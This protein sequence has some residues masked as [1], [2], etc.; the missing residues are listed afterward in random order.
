MA[1]RPRLAGRRGRRAAGRRRR[2]EPPVAGAGGGVGH[3]AGG[4]GAGRPEPRRG[5]PRRRHG[6]ADRQVPGALGAGRPR[7]RP[8]EECV[9]DARRRLGAG[10]GRAA[11]PDVPRLLGAAADAVCR[12][13]AA[14]L[15][16]PAT[17]P[18]ARS[19]SEVSE[20]VLAG[21]AGEPFPAAAR[22]PSEMA[23]DMTRW[24]TPVTS[25]RAARLTVRLGSPEDDGGWLLTV[26]AQGEPGPDGATAVPQPVEEVLHSG[27]PARAAAVETEL[28]RLERLLPA[29]RRPGRRRGQ[30]V[31]DGTEAWELMTTGGAVLEAAGFTVRVPAAGQEAVDAPPPAPRRGLRRRRRSSAPSSCRG[32]SGRWR[33]TTSRSTPPPSASWPCRPVRWSRPRA[34]GSSSTR[35]TSKRP[36]RL[37]RRGRRDGDVGRRDPP[38][39]RRPR[40]RRRRAGAGRRRRLGRRPRARRRRRSRP[41]AAGARGLR[42]RAAPLPGRGPGVARRSSTGPASAAAWPWTWASARPPPSSPT[43]WST[44]TRARR[45]SS[46]RRPCSAT[47][48]PRP[49]RFTPE[50]DG[51]GPPRRRPGRP[52][53]E[54]ADEAAEADIVLTTYAT[55]RARRRGAGQGRMGP[56]HRRRGPGHQEP[57]QRHRPGAAPHPG[58][59][60]PRPH[61]HPGG[62]RPRRPVVDPR[63]HQPRP[64]RAPPGV[65]RAVVPAPGRSRRRG[66][67]RH[68][69]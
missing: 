49:H 61:R 46:P 62:E 7:A 68:R 2:P 38:P 43:C 18:V 11:L 55:G 69:R 25:D 12:A 47:G 66:A 41:S 6:R 1:C 28:R 23:D 51:P 63:L 34:A 35:P 20:A 8:P 48:R 54:V 64:G 59:Q 67:R 58:P 3:G 14:R 17:V 21:L 10:A 5:Q 13:G 65:H 32:C 44:R 42:R 56:P 15:V 31:M 27:R 26:E 29:L 50:A 19:R 36:P 57:G 53:T 45:S 39:R 30:V 16:T 37:W 60:P 22:A 40:R 33:S 52:A 9:R 24:T 4:P